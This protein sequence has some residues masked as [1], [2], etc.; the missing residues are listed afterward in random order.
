MHL[1]RN[2]PTL[3][4]VGG[5]AEHLEKSDIKQRLRSSVHRFIIFGEV[6]T[7]FGRRKGQGRMQFGVGKLRLGV[8]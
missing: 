5:W 8:M 2:S 7:E 4:E 3:V 1:Y 6:K